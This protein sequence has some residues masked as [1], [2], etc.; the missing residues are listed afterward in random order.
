[1]PKKK[2]GKKDGKKNGKSDAEAKDKDSD[3]KQFEAPG[4]SEKEIILRS[5]LLEL[6]HE[7]DT[8]KKQV[9][10]LRS[11]N[12]WLQKEAERT[13]EESQDYQTY[14]SRKAQK[15]QSLIVS[16]SDH[17]QQELRMIQQQKEEVIKDHEEK[18]AGLNATLLEKENELLKIQKELKLLE[19][20]KMLQ[21]DQEQEIRHLEEEL[22][23][24][25]FQH[26]D[27]IRSMKTKFL[28]E[29]KAFEEAT[30][31]R[32][33]TMAD[34]A[35]KQ[36]TECLK[37]HTLEIKLENQRLRSELQQII[38]ET[39]D[40]QLQKKRLDKQY[41]TLLREHQ[42]NQDLQRLRG[43]VFKGLHSSSSHTKLDTDI[44]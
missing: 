1:M 38:E 35:N 30:E 12:E 28:R 22:E 10:D 18:K 44:Y 11:E 9:S 17:N 33:R 23:E 3:K 7:L 2:K 42:F 37:K 27:R 43:S 26:E 13:K 40:L 32:I 31:A 14:V 36:A 25:R 6:D 29:K 16:L 19:P 34:S 41:R 20:Y 8:L 5:E 21:Q 24:R 4:A 15:R 39:N